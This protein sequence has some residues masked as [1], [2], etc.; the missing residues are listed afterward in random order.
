[1]KIS[2][3]IIAILLLIILL[4]IVT[5]IHISIS[6]NH[7]GDNDELKIQLTAWKFIKYTIK[8]PL[9][10]IDENSPAIVVKQKQKASA[11]V[12]QDEKKLKFTIEYMVEQVKKIREFIEHITG[13]YRIIKRLLKRMNIN[14]FQWKSEIGTSDAALTG[15]LTGLLWSMKGTVI[16]IFSY[17]MNLREHPKLE[18]TPNFQTAISKTHIKCMISFRLGHAIFAGLLIVREWKRRPKQF[19]TTSESIKG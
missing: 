6:Y 10:K 15:V 7:D 18:I 14:E 8:V 3:I 4:L 9:I 2:M 16:G 1:M 13:F 19:K 5:K 17:Y 11:N 12:I